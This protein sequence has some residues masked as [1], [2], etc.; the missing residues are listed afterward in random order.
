LL[1]DGTPAQQVQLTNAHHGARVFTKQA[2]GSVTVAP[3]G[4]IGHNDA[5]LETLANR[6]G[7]KIDWAQPDLK[8]E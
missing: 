2:D 7:V 8:H 3:A 5:D 6:I 4:I 1:D